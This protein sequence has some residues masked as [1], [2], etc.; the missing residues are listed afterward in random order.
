MADDFDITSVITT[1]HAPKQ[2]HL[3]RIRLRVVDGPDAGKQMEYETDVV[4]IGKAEAADLTLTDDTVSRKHAE[5]VRDRHGYLLRDLGSTNGSFVGSVRVREVY[6]GEARNFRVG[7]TEIQFTP[8]DEV[9]DIVPADQTSFE[10][11]V[12]ASIVMREVFSIIERVARTELTVLITGETGTGKELVSR[13]IHSRSRRSKG[14]FV[15]FDCGAV[16]KNLIESELFGHERGAFT[17]AVAPRAGVFEQANG[18]TIF[19]DELGEL[20]IELQPALLRVL[21]QR[22]VRRVG[23][24]RVRPIDVRVV[25]ATNRDMREQVEQGAFRSDLYYRLAVVEMVLPPLRTRREDFPLLV[26]HLLRHAPFEHKVRRTSPDV[27]DLF[28]QYNW[29][30]N[31]RELRNVVLRAIP[32]C[33]GD[34]IEMA[35]L[36]DAFRRADDNTP[37][38][39]AARAAGPSGNVSM[40]NPGE[41]SLREAR[42]KIIDAFER[43]Y[44]EDILEACDGNISKAA[45]MAGVDRKTIARMLKRHGIK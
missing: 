16:P 7:K 35:A 33:D 27:H 15:V 18:G 34:T 39:A 4:H 3:R 20:P 21:E 11:M 41:L 32:F 14:P 42:D 44:L 24:R 37:Q 1:G 5:I 10:G 28:A 26:E 17:G 13:A 30:G 6:L 23:D 22:E 19:I 2:L 43:Q 29:P 40:P 9:V 38:G 31:I 45:R 12:G 25:A 8:A 36:P